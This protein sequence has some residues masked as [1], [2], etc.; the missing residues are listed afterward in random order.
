MQ[1]VSFG[2][3]SGLSVPRAN[4]GA[5][6]LPQDQGE[7]VRLIRHAIDRGM[8]YIDTCRGYGDSELKV[9]A[10]LRGGWRDRVILSSKWSPWIK[11]FADDDAPTAACMRLRLEESLGRLGVERIDFYQVWNVHDDSSFEAATRPGGTADG[12]RRAMEDGLVAHTGLTTHYAPGKLLER[13]PG[14]DWCEVL[15]VSY[16]MLDTSYGPVIARARELG[17]GTIVMNPLAGGRLTGG[18]PELLE[19]ARSAGAAD[20]PTLALRWLLS[21]RDLDTYISGISKLSDVDSAVAAAEAGPLTAEA[22]ARVDAFIAGRSRDAV[23]FCTGCGYCQPCPQG[24]NIPE[25]MARLYEA[26]FWGLR[27]AAARRYLRIPKPR[28]DACVACGKCEAK[29]TQKLKIGELMREAARDFG[30]EEG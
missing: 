26:R 14:L 21:N 29:C 16:N 23:G 4:I 18:G 27:E 24:I 19:L 17:I 30:G 12:I 8:R 22:K 15:L 1:D 3:R 11:K 9:G 10:A 20:V 25:V 7:A 5:M 2:R 6:R 13:L 28:A